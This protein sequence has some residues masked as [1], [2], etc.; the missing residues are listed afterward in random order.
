MTFKMEMKYHIFYWLIIIALFLLLFFHKS[1]NNSTENKII[2]YKVD[3]IKTEKKVYIPVVKIDTINQKE[4][5]Y[6]TVYYSLKI[7]RYKYED[8]N[9]I[10]SFDAAYFDV[11]SLYYKIKF[12]PHKKENLILNISLLNNGTVYFTLIKPYGFLNP[13]LSIGYNSFNKNITYGLGI[14]LRF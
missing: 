9:I 5:K 1:Q 10:L 6:D 7:N 8:K 14:T 4:I 11:N 13:S 2:E 3:T 12:S